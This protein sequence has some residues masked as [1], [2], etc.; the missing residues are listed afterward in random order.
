[1][2]EAAVTLH[3]FFEQV[4]AGHLSALR[5]GGCGELSIPPRE[6]CPSCQQR[7]WRLEPLSGEGT[8]TSFTVIR[9]PPARHAGD[10]PY[11]VGVVRLKEGASLFG[12]LVDIPLDRLA[13]GLAVRFRPLVLHDQPAVGFGPA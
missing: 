10:A 13:I 8:V 3:D 7:A 12:R 9:V 1:M 6:F 4:R 2:S 5:C 11:A